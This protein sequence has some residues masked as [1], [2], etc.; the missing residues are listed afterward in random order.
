MRPRGGAL[1]GGGAPA[2]RRAAA[3]P[4]GRCPRRGPAVPAAD[5]ATANFTARSGTREENVTF[6]WRESCCV[7]TA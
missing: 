5:A 7:C 4:N 2:W 1:G 3:A 6:Q